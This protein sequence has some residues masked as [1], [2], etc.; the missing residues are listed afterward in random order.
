MLQYL[1]IILDESCTSFC[2]YEKKRVGSKLISLET[3]KEGIV[4][5]MKENLFIQYIYPEKRLPTEYEKLIESFEHSKIVSSTC[6]DSELQEIAD[7][8]VFDGWECINNYP[9]RKDQAYILRTTK[10]DFFIHNKEFGELSRNSGHFSVVFTDVTTFTKEDFEKY[11]RVLAELVD[12]FKNFY[13]NQETPQTNLLT[14]R[15]ILNKMNNCGAGENTITLAP[16]GKL[17]ICPGFYNDNEPESAGDIFSGYDIKNK[18]LYKLEYSPICRHCDAFQC[19]RCI[20]LNKKTTLEVNIPSHEQ[21]VTAH[22]ERNASRE[23]LN[24]IRSDHTFLPEQEIEQIDYLDPF[25]KR[26]TW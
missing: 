16:N 18:Q 21:C 4:F 13:I 14:D 5:A 12:L 26:E 9:L 24:G 2:H 7:A 22:L 15:L 8:I 3:L 11:N 19:K 6:E 23:L 25:E 1:I 10:N 17:Y 20:W